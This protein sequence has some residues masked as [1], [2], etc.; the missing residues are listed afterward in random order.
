[1]FVA[2]TNEQKELEGHPNKARLKNTPTHKGEPIKPRGI[3]GEAEKCW[4]KIVPHL[5]S[6]G[7]AK[8]I[9]SHQLE[10]LCVWW[11]FYKNAVTNDDMNAA[12]RAWSNFNKL[13]DQFGLSPK[14][15]NTINT[16]PTEDALDEF[17]K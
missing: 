8:E 13:A 5:V 11:A 12:H 1:M 3:K 9:D 16:S 7:V 15:R 6:T 4:N 14:A 10:A 17:L 2:K